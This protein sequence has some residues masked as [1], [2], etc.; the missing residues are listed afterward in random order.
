MKNIILPLLLFVSSIAHSQ[1]YESVYQVQSGKYNSYSKEWTWSE[2]QES[3]LIITLN[4]T[5]VLINN[6]ANTV[7]TTYED[8]GE[9]R[10]TDKD[11]DKLRTHSW[12]AVD[13]KSRKCLFLMTFYDDLP[14]VVYS[15]IYNDTGFRFYIKS[16]KLSNF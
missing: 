13:N 4:G 3:E 15:V 2:L 12:R 6:N 9:E 16:N 1:K 11:G 10:K 7:I 5:T 14:L 8:L